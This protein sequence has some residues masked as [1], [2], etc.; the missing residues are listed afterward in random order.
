MSSM[1]RWLYSARRWRGLRYLTSA[2][3]CGTLLL[4][5][6]PSSRASVVTYSYDSSGRLYQAIYDNGI[7]VTYFY[8]ANGN[9]TGAQVNTPALET[10]TD[11][12]ATSPSGTQVSLTWTGSSGATG[13]YIWRCA[14]NGCTNFAE[15]GSATGASYSDNGLAGLTTYVYEVQAYK[16]SGSTTITSANS[17]PA[18]ATTGANPPAPPTN[19]TASASGT[20]ISLAWTAS[21]DDVGISSYTVDTCAGS[22]CSWAQLATP[23]STTYT[24]SGLSQGVTY[25]YR[26]LATNTANQQ[27]GW[28][29]TAS[30]TVPVT[31][32]PRAPSSLTASAPKWS[33]V[34]LSW[35]A[36][37]DPI[38]GVA[39]AG[40][41]IYRNGTAIGGTTSA[42]TYTD[43]TTAPNTTYTYKVEAYDAWHNYSGPATASVTT[44]PA[45]SPST[46]AGLR[47]TP[48]SNS[49]ITLTWSA[50]SDSGG[51]G[52]AGYKIY[53]N[54][55]YVGSSTATT[56]TDTGRT[57]FS[58]Y[59]YTV[60]AYDKYNTLSAQ[61]AAAS[62]TVGYEIAN[63]TGLLPAGSAYRI[64]QGEVPYSPSEYYW[65]VY[66]PN[67]QEVASAE[68]GANGYEPACYDDQN[69]EYST[70]SGYQ[71][72]QC[73]LWAAPSVYQP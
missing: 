36:A 14:G 8:D 3:I 25:E 20:A 43:S 57:T 39:I 34:N 56:Y 38:T 69:G 72:Q 24:V 22:S 7:V 5:S 70:A 66:A 73:I 4:A 30:A 15:V 28:S 26:V 21:T 35:T 51:P 10:P 61:S 16:T 68:T 52:V 27:S 17:T 12:S 59:S 67:G 11:L 19:L 55:V 71:L 40:Y 1:L 58:T 62:V 23:S 13:Y 9:R 44:P 31:T 2:L 42:T 49:S 54:G 63:S 46:P 37:T 6:S 48:A 32:A 29:S 18:S 41:E 33:T 47:G 60:A 53:R 64:S 50:A 45:P 65:Y